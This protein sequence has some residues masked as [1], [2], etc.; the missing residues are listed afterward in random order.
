MKA[1]RGYFGMAG[2]Q[3]KW[4]P[5]ED[6]I[7]L[8]DPINGLRQSGDPEI[9]AGSDLLKEIDKETIKKA[10]KFCNEK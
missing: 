10:K 3:V 7:W 4:F 1:E 2:D 8:L 5:S 6:G 9:I